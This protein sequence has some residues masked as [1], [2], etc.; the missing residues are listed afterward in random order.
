MSKGSRK[1][2]PRKK[3]VDLSSEE[4]LRYL[5]TIRVQSQTKLW[6]GILNF[7]LIAEVTYFKRFKGKR[8]QFLQFWEKQVQ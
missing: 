6:N 8:V 2:A 4:S 3:I 7:A 1:S 5:I